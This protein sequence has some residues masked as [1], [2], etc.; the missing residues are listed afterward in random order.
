MSLKPNATWS[1]ADQGE[2]ERACSAS[3][4]GHGAAQRESLKGGDVG[5][6]KDVLVEL[7]NLGD[8]KGEVEKK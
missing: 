5:E 4:E 2:Q 8:H 3:T 1:K 7:A 6:F